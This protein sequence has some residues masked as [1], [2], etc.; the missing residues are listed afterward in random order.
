[1]HHCLYACT[2]FLVAPDLWG[3]PHHVAA[4]HVAVAP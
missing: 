1:M 2:V 4:K 3:W